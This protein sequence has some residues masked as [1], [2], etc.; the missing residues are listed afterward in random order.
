MFE[1][2]PI[3]K[4]VNF[5]GDKDTSSYSAFFSH[6][7]P[8]KTGFYKKYV[9]EILDNEDSDIV[10]FCKQTPTYLAWSEQQ[11]PGLIEILTKVCDKLGLVVEEPRCTVYSNFFAAKAD[12]YKEYVQLLK[13]A[14]DIMETDSEIKELCW[15]DANYKTGLSS[16]DLKKYTELDY[17]TFH[18]FVLERL[19]SIWIDNKKLTYA[20]YT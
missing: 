8:H 7:F 2:N 18:T 9:E 16:K 12:V 11:H 6:K 1:Y 15:K 17:Y 4:T 14:I 19:M 10:V 5:W 3:I 13:K 20:V